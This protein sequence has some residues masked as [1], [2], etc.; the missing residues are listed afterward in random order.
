MAAVWTFLIIIYRPIEVT[1]GLITGTVTITSM[2]VDGVNEVNWVNGY[3]Y[4]FKSGQYFWQCS[5]PAVH[6]HLEF[7]TFDRLWT[8]S[9]VPADKHTYSDIYHGLASS[10]GG[11]PG[12][13][14]QTP[15]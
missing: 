1:L 15:V 2:T 8:F 3:G 5:I 14:P 12:V 7:T 6:N 9:M 11:Y 10:A 4:E 13:V